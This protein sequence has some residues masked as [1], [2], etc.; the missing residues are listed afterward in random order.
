M[1]RLPHFPF[2]TPT[3]WIAP[4]AGSLVLLTGLVALFPLPQFVA[5]AQPMEPGMRHSGM[6]DGPPPMFEQLNLTEE[7][8]EQI[9]TL[10]EQ[11]MAT[12]ESQRQQLQEAHEEMRS[13]LTSDASADELRQQH[14]DMQQLRQTLETQHFEMML[15]IREI[16]TPEQRAEL[17]EMGPPDH[18]R[19]H[20][21]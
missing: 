8:Q 17:A 10:H 15:S 6:M 14:Q 12:T 5:L 21:R 2:L 11:T 7:Q 1:K 19:G 4:V 20:D 3:T 13:L 9:R 18:H 16:L